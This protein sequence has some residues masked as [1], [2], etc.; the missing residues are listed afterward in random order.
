MRPAVITL[1]VW[2]DSIRHS[3]SVECYHPALAFRLLDFPAVVVAPSADAVHDDQPH[4]QHYMVQRGRSCAIDMRPEDLQEALSANPGPG[5][6][7]FAHSTATAPGLLRPPCIHP[8]PCWWMPLPPHSLHLMRT[9]PHADSCCL[10]RAAAHV[11]R[12][13]CYRSRPA[14]GAH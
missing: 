5:A 9:L 8:R 3:D 12:S 1:N 7:L 2:V 6:P 13:C 11:D 10:S 4:P 14:V